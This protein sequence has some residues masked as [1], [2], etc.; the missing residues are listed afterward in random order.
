VLE[1]L[2]STSARI[3]HTGQLVGGKN[4]HD[5]WTSPLDVR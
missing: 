3:R 2:L 4:G 5:A 1:T